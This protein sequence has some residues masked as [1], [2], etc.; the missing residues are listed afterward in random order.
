VAAF[1][2]GVWLS[3]GPRRSLRI[4]GVL[5]MVYGFVGIFWPPMH[6][7]EVLAAGGG[8]LIDILHIVFTFSLFLIMAAIAYAASAFGR[9]F[10]I[11]SIASLVAMFVFGALTGVASPGIHAGQP[12]PW[13]G[14]WERLSAAAFMLWIAVLAIALQRESGATLPRSKPSPTVP[15]DRL[16]ARS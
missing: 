14:V 8:T 13:V 16:L 10:R 12:T 9:R 4:A 11:Y 3:A 7:R 2:Y 5:M 1:G 15:H 6:R